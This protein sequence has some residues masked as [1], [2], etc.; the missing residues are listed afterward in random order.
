MVTKVYIVRHAEAIGN[1]NE[2]FQGRT[3]EN[4]TEKGYKQLE[5]LSDRFRD[6]HIDVLY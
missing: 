6:I 2:T 4:V 3:D 1:I 5:A